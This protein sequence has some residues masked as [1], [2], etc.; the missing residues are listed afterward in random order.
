M[1]TKKKLTV[2]IY[3]ERKGI[4]SAP[5]ELVDMVREQTRIKNMILNALKDVPKTVPELAEELKIDSYKLFWYLMTLWKGRL[6]EPVEKTDEGYWKY[7]SV[8]R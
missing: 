4:K 6:I 7:K 5:R 1:S 3:K 2:M 8:K